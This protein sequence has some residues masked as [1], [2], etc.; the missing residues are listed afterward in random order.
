MTALHT[1]IF[2]F[3]LLLIGS[4]ALILE[5]NRRIG[6]FQGQ[7]NSF[8]RRTPQQEDLTETDS[9]V[10]GGPQFESI[11]EIRMRRRSKY[12]KDKTIFGF[13]LFSEVFNG[14]MAMV[15]ITLGFINEATTGKSILQ[16]I[17]L[18]DQQ[19]QMSF[20]TVVGIVISAVA[21]NTLKEKT[22]LKDL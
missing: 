22:I 21:I 9:K 10:T 19:C 16:Q 2:F 1:V 12:S 17:G 7:K 4:Q 15:G 6:K 20:L 3:L 14:R 5:P 11:E 18:S 13:T 8:I